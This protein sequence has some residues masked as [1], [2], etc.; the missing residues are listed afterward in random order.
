MQFNPDMCRGRQ[1]CLWCRTHPMWRQR[2]GAPEQCAEG[3]AAVKAQMSEI[4]EGRPVVA[5][6]PVE[7][8]WFQ[9][10]VL[11]CQACRAA[12]EHPECLLMKN[13]ASC[14]CNSPIKDPSEQCPHGKWAAQE[15]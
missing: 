12:N 9:K 11:L 13:Q 8:N 2:V 4:K 3:D 1:H 15:N 10:R 7:L 6:V 14:G 5:R